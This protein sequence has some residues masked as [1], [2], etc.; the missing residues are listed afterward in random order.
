MNQKK[1]LLVDVT[2]LF[3]QYSKRGIGRYGK[4]MV[5][6][7][8]LSNQFDLHLI[9]FKTFKE[10]L[11]EF[12]I[13]NLIDIKFHSLG[14]PVPSGLRNIFRWGDY[15]R[16]IN[17]IKPDLFYAV[18]FERGLPSTPFLRSGTYIGTK[19]IVTCH[20]II[21]FVLPDFRYSKKGGIQSFIKSRFYSAM[22]AGISNADLVITVSEH[23]KKDIIKHKKI[24]EDKIKTVYLGIS[25][26]FTKENF[27]K[28]S[29]NLSKTLKD[30]QLEDKNYFLYD[31]GLEF[32]KGVDE[33]LQIFAG[34]LKAS[35]KAV[36]NYL[37]VTGGDFEKGSGSAIR[38]K[39]N[40]GRAFLKIARSLNIL[41]NLVTTSRISDFEL[42]AI[43][44]N[45]KTYINMSKYEG[46]GFGPVQAMA[47]RVPAIVSNLS[48][49]PE[50]TMGGAFLVDP[51]Q[52]EESVQRV[53]SFL[54]D[55][56]AVQSQV[57]KG[58][59]VSKT[60]SWDKSAQE[61]IRYLNS[62]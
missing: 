20:D 5:R 28:Q 4:E 57:E 24:P 32:N 41:E 39:T 56:K 26:I 47:M 21:P 12:E 27:E 25:D 16:V 43:L 40:S 35:N 46:F 54:T 45:S 14:D 13:N 19:T 2:F 50:I 6:R 8:I 58:Y 1:K 18:H 49:F 36:P 51:V 23:S 53:L 33:L 11:A 29:I 22:W 3:D 38:A 62:V 17:Q 7:I 37:V 48:C 15:S 60:Y 9:G 59:E 61:L 34:I 30:F 31:G 55:S 42:A 10:N 52:V 44:S